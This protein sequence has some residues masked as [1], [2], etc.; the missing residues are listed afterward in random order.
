MSDERV[1][2]LANNLIRYSVRLQPREKV[3]I[4]IYDSGQ[5][6][7]RE[8]IAA[9]Y[10]V[11]GM[12]FLTIKNT[13]LQRKLL[14]DSQEE[15]IRQIA[16]WEAERMSAM[17]A[18]IAVR[19]YDNASELADLPDDKG[20]LYQKYWWKA[21][22]TDIRIAKTKWCVLRYPGP[23]M[24]QMAGMSSEAFRDFYFKVSNLDYA[25]LAE[26][27][28]PLVEL[29]EQTEDV[30]ITGPGTE[31]S[32]S[33]KGIPVMKS[34]GLRN[35]PD[36]EVFTAPVKDSVNGVITYNCPTIFQG[37][38]FD[39]VRFRFA[40]GRIVE[41]TANN[42]EKL[43]RI[44]DTD[45]GSRYIGEFSLGLNPHIHQPMRDILF[46]EKICGSFHLT[47]GNAYETAFNGNRSAIHWDLVAIQTPA[48][49]GGEI[50][51][52]G[53]L[54]RKDGRFVLPELAGLNPE[55]WQ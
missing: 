3:L 25:R 10:R 32:F 55:N 35:I 49:G 53:R 48:C 26:A 34:C 33:I 18:Y 16:T 37:I 30:R 1:R 31:L 51:F 8:L 12:P 21:V 23:S 5:E 38:A 2:Q 22:H 43:N 24:A 52:D 54:V 9:A 13:A 39:N 17:D 40:Q 14:L 11:G 28:Q 4:E 42:T 45:E 44:L 47:P 6:L 27:E 20:A 15:Q 7:A 46:D 41:A 50:W 29:F 36:G 19:A